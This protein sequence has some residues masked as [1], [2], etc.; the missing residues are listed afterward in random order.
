[1]SMTRRQIYAG[2]AA[3]LAIGVVCAFDN[4]LNVITSETLGEFEQ[5]AVASKV[6]D[7]GGIS[8]SSR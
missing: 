3:C 4:A 1:M 5:N 6:I 7:M 8:A 2:Y